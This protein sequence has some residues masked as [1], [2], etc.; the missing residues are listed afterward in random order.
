M[1]PQIPQ[2][3]LT[4]ESVSTPIVAAIALGL[5][6]IGAA[7]MEATARSRYAAAGALSIALIAWLAV[8]YRKT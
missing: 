3:L 5:I 7:R 8:G 2:Y 1:T 6:W 4:F